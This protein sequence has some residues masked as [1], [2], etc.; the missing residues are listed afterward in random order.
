MKLPQKKKKKIEEIARD[1]LTV[2]INMPLDPQHLCKFHLF[3]YCQ[4]MPNYVIL[5]SF[6]VF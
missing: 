5:L 6:D 4:I 2:E 3:S 1:A